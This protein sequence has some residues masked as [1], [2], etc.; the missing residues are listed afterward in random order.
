MIIIIN[1]PCKR[2]GAMAMLSNGTTKCLFHCLNN[3]VLS[4]IELT[5]SPAPVMPVKLKHNRPNVT[6]FAKT[7]HNSARTEIHFIA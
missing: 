4:Y 6:G 5:Q 1:H 7:Q 2:H 3:P